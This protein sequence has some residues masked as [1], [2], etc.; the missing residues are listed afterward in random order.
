MDLI[1]V[2]VLKQYNQMRN[3]VLEN[4][5]RRTKLAKLEQLQKQQHLLQVNKTVVESPV[6]EDNTTL[7]RENPVLEELVVE[8]RVLEK[9]PKQKTTHIGKVIETGSIR[10]M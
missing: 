8:E 4:L 2:S 7:V 1:N 3:G 5:I 10:K 6:L 9:K